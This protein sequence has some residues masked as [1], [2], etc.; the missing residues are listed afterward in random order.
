[1]VSTDWNKF[2]A[3]KPKMTNNTLKL[4]VTKTVTD[5]SWGQI[6]ELNLRHSEWLMRLI[7]YMFSKTPMYTASIQQRD[8]QKPLRLIV[9]EIQHVYTTV[10][11]KTPSSW[12]LAHYSQRSGQC[13]K[14]NAK[15]LLAPIYSFNQSSWL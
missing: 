1:M 7:K 9:R 4:S 3:S 15:V 2:H 10:V 14:L 11:S 13:E 5:S 8:W 6:R 12:S